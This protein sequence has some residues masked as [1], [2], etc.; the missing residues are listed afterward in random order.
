VGLGI[1]TRSSGTETG[2]VKSVSRTRRTAHIL[3]VAPTSRAFDGISRIEEFMGDI[4]A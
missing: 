2:D 3:S 4:W 1:E